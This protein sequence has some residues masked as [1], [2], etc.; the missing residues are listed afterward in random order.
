MLFAPTI[1]ARARACIEARKSQPIPSHA[2]SLVPTVV[3]MNLL[4]F[5]AVYFEDSLNFPL[6]SAGFF[7]GIF[8]YPEG[9]GD[10]FFRKVWLSPK[11]TA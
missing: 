3:T 4:G 10:M 2:R 7:L 9:G 6:V 1:T 11:Y 8:F 5:N